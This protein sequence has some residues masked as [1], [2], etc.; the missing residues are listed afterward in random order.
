MIMCYSNSLSTKT[1]AFQD[2]FNLPPLK[3][4]S[5]TPTY[6]SSAF[7]FP[8]WPILTKEGV[9]EIKWGLIPNWFNGEINDIRSKT[10]NARSETALEKP[11]FK[12]SIR[13]NHCLIPST[14][15]FEWQTVGKKKHA[16]FIRMKES[17]IF[18]MAGIFSEWTNPKTGIIE[19]TFS[20]L[21]TEANELMAEIHN[22]KK[23]MPLILT[24]NQED[25]WL[26]SETITNNDLPTTVRSNELISHTID[27]RI[28]LSSN[29]NVAEAQH[30]FEYPFEGEQGSLF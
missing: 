15:F 12:D 20:M 18:T 1:K 13:H 6:F 9:E 28:I 23:R 30:F 26:H 22:T 5:I 17:E 2:R 11:S 25:D 29:S 21:T 10:L 27:K 24:K 4:F 3:G 19:K 8:S 14:G 16:H 7:T